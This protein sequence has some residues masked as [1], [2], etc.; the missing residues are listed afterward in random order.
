MLPKTNPAA[1]HATH[2]MAPA[3]AAVQSQPPFAQQRAIL[4]SLRNGARVRNAGDLHC[5]G[6]GTDSAVHP[7]GAPSGVAEIFG[8]RGRRLPIASPCRC[9]RWAG[10]ADISTT[11]EAFSVGTPFHVNGCRFASERHK[12]RRDVLA[13]AFADAMCAIVPP[14]H[15]YL[16]GGLRC[17][18]DSPAP[19]GSIPQPLVDGA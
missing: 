12:K 11:G 5:M 10:D 4:R 15:R 8:T 7:G 17:Q 2:S 16:G 3:R 9:V 18:F 13:T 1:G 14:C 19:V 6:K